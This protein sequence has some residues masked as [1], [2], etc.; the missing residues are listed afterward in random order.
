LWSWL[1][2]AYHNNLAYLARC[3][4]LAGFIEI[5]PGGA[6]AAWRSGWSAED[7]AE[8]YRHHRAPIL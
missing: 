8:G 3:L 2:I 5:K 6:A 4:N 1:P 7:Y